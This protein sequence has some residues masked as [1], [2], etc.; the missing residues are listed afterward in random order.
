MT[1]TML[2]QGGASM[3]APAV[4]AIIPAYGRPALLARAL[5]SLSV[6]GRALGE[7]MVVNN[8]R[9][10]TT[11]EAAAAAGMPVR[12]LTPA[13]NL[14]TAG[15]IAWALRTWLE[16]GKGTH[17][18]ILD[19]D[20][21]AAPDALEAMLAVAP[22]AAAVAPLL[23]DSTGAV[24]WLPGLHQDA[25]R[26]ADRQRL[27]PA[28]FRGRFGAGPLPWDWALWASLLVSRPAVASVG[29]PRVD[30]WSQFSDLEYTLRLSARYPTVL[31]P[32]AVC[33]HDPPEA[34]EGPEFRAKLRSALQNAGFVAT[35]SSHGR[36]VVRHLPGLFFRFLR[37]YRFVLASW[38]DA[39]VSL[40]QGAVLG[41]PSGSTLHRAEVRQAAEFLAAAP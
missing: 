4:C 28:Q 31:A 23:T 25:A 33:R 41:R 27:S 38:S 10:A 16:E 13:C 17:A 1:E 6:Q 26:R 7:V 11:A 14:G 35:R 18:W 40:W 20:A 21:E 12:V 30:L 36:R 15:G 9:D 2:G 3:Q 22:T 8:S 5:A 24:R 32:L 34:R 19:D 37:H 29:L 39:V